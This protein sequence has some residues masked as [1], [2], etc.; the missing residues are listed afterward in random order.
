MLLF[1]IEAG[2]HPSAFRSAN[3]ALSSRFSIWSSLSPASGPVAGGCRSTC[4]GPSWPPSVAVSSPRFYSAPRCSCAGGAPSPTSWPRPPRP[5]RTSRR[6]SAPCR[7]PSP[8][9]RARPSPC[10][11]CEPPVRTAPRSNFLSAPPR[12]PNSC[13]R[14]PRPAVLLPKNGSRSASFYFSRTSRN[15][16]RRG[17]FRAN[18]YP[19]PS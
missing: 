14:L 15:K 19:N 9:G 11:T 3:T 13:F 2:S 4:R 18:E 17:L 16:W 7:P 1:E 12:R 10:C 6:R 5:P 8:G